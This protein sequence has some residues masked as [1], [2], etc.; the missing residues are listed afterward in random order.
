M[1]IYYVTKSS[2]F[3]IEK[4]NDNA[5]KSLEM[6]SVCYILICMMI[7]DKKRGDLNL[8]HYK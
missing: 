6:K 8:C 7:S 1:N 3:I 2:C 4:E 5:K